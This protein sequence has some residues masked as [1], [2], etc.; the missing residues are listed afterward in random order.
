MCQRQVKGERV[1]VQQ[2]RQEFPNGEVFATEIT[3]CVLA[4][5]VRSS[6]LYLVS[7]GL[8]TTTRPGQSKTRPSLHFR[9]LNL[10]AAP[11]HVQVRLRYRNADTALFLFGLRFSKKMKTSR[12]S[13]AQ[14]KTDLKDLLTPPSSDPFIRL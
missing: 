13:R 9:E 7:T 2:D 6:V 14:E 4:L 8:T 11:R 1:L 3:G 10:P 5:A 12:K